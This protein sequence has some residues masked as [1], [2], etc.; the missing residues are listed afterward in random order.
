MRIT[1]L[2]ISLGILLLTPAAH[3]GPFPDPREQ[4]SAAQCPRVCVVRASPGGSVSEFEA[5]ADDIVATRRVLVVDGQCD[6]ACT[7]MA[8]R[9][10]DARGLICATARARMGYHQATNYGRDESGA[11]VPVSREPIAYPKDIMSWI[12]SKGGEPTQGMITMTQPEVWRHYREC[13][14]EMINYIRTYLTSN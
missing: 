1:G 2:L 10:R 3:A 11:W 13:S 5:M 12:N 9:I 6:S 8:Y 7:I 14:V 4:W